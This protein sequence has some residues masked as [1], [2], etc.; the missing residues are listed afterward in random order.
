MIDA[1]RPIYTLTVGEFIELYREIQASWGSEENTQ[2]QP[3][4]LPDRRYVYGIFGLATLLG[5]S[6]PT[7]QRI[8]NSGKIDAAISQEGRKIIVDADK[9][10]ELLSNNQ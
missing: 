9:V 5:C 7:A 8:K 1:Q 6:K 4:R 10:L 3:I 2:Q